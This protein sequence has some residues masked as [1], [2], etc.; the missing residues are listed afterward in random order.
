MG[1][2]FVGKGFAD[3]MMSE[4]G[5]KEMFLDRTNRL[6]DWKHFEKILRVCEKRP[7]A[8]GNDP[9]PPIVMFKALLVQRWHCLSDPEM[10]TALYDRLSF[11]RFCGLSVMSSVPDHSTI[12]RFREELLRMGL[13]EKLFAEVNRQLI[14]KGIMVKETKGAIV[15]ATLI[16]SSRRPRKVIEVMP[17]DRK[18]EETDTPEFTVTYSDDT[19]ATWVKKGNTP[20]YGYK[21][22]VA[23]DVEDG[24]ILG[25]H[26]TPANVSDINQL[27]KTLE[28]SKVPKGSCV[29]GDKGYSSEKNRDM[30]AEKGHGD[31]L[32][33]KAVKNKPLTGL[34][35]IVNRMISKVRYKVEQGF[36]ILKKHYGFERMR[37]RGLAKANMEFIL[38]AMVFNIKKAVLK[39]E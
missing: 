25:G 34:Q 12:W 23:A 10:E 28:V 38:N 24:F 8:A 16:K 36:G 5:Q 33:N 19:D 27:E 13:F 26:V 32:M 39:T 14:E 30:L 31:L 22:H 20:H 9:Y 21:A 17:E 3:Q 1:K 2:K 37:Y 7:D 15:D 4:R 6:I 29:I 11:I 18:E 35:K